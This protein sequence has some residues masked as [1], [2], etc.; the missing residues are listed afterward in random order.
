MSDM[1]LLPCEGNI[2]WRK[3]VRRYGVCVEKFSR[4]YEVS[5]NGV[6][7]FFRIVRKED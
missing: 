1:W 6:V 2:T 5:R 4:Y 7:R 3:F